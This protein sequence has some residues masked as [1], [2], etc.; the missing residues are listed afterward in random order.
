MPSEPEDPKVTEVK[1]RHARLK[2]TADVMGAGAPAILLRYV[3]D[4]GALLAAFSPD[5]P[6]APAQTRSDLD[7]ALEHDALGRT[8]RR[9]T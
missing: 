1:H 3:E 9:S 5:P 7:E 6:P 2:Q 8:E 4:V